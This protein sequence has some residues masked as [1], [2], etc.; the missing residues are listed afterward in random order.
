MSKPFTASLPI[1]TQPV[2][3][4]EIERSLLATA[5]GTLEHEMARRFDREEGPVGLFALLQL[6]TPRHR[7]RVSELRTQHR[8]ILAGLRTLR[9]RVDGD[10]EDEEPISEAFD[11]LVELIEHHEKAEYR[12]LHEALERAH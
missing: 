3:T 11:A 9:E 6:A 4:V 12:L 10:D 8:L 1:D 7:R 5:L 2:R